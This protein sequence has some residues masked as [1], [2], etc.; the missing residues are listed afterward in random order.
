MSIWLNPLILN[1]GSTLSEDFPETL[2]SILDRPGSRQINIFIIN[3]PNAF[4]YAQLTFK[5]IEFSQERIGFPTDSD[6]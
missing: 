6:S 1:L 2:S 3:H 5:V 4:L